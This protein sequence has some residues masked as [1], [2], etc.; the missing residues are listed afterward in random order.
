MNTKKFLLAV[1]AG[2]VGNS[3][4]YAILE[5][6][7]LKGYMAKEVYEP[8]GASVG[9]APLMAFVAVLSMSLIMAYIYPKGYQGGKPLYEGSRFGILLGLF[10]GIPFGIF[11]G[12]MFS[13]GSVPALVLILVYA[14]EVAVAG[15]LIGLVYGRA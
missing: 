15:L 11:F 10:A 8:A 12:L 13:I 2:F 4:A 7:L 9:G 6:L 14:L 3:V 1:L 5:E